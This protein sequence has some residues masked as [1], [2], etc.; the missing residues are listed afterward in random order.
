MSDAKQEPLE[1]PEPLAGEGVPVAA[2][3]GDE[4]AAGAVDHLQL[5]QAPVEAFPPWSGWDVLAVVGFTTA[6]IFVCSMIA[7]GIARLATAGRHVTVSELASNTSVIIGAQIAAYPVVILFMMTLVGGKS[8]EKFW[9]AIRWRWPGAAGL[10]F[11]ISGL[12]LALMV[13]FIS[14][15]LPIPPSLPVDKYFGEIT[16]AYLMS[17]FGVTLAPLLEELFFRGMLYPLMRRT[18]GVTVAVLFTATMFALIHGAQLGYAWAPL[19][20]IFVVG[21]VFTLVR[22]KTGSVAASFLTHCGYNLALFGMLWVGSDHFR[23]LEKVTN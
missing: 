20:S 17:A 8:G 5:T 22:E 3:P 7:L 16:G 14:R 19:L 12:A 18:A 15:F 23:H 6:S 11:L 9:Q 21:V 2:T 10:R 1:L 4:F 13:E